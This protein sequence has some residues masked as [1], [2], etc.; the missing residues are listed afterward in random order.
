MD[1]ELKEL[2]ELQAENANVV[3]E[4]SS[5]DASVPHT[6]NISSYGADYDVD[7]L[8]KRMKNGHIF[9]PPFQ[10]DYVW[11]LRDASRLI[12]SLLLGLPV[13]GIFLAK[14]SESNKL[15]VIDGQQR[16]KT[17][18][19]FYEGIFNQKPDDKKV[20]LFRLSNVQPQFEGKLYEDLDEKDKL[21]LNDTIIHATIIKQESPEGDDTSVYH[22]FERLNTGGR[23]LT[24]QEI[25]VAI[26]HGDLIDLLRKLNATPSWRAIFGKESNRLKDQELILRFLAM[27]SEGDKYEKP[28]SEFLSKF[29][30]KCRVLSA[31]QVRQFTE[32]FVKTIDTVYKSVGAHAF[33][34]ERAL[35]AAVFD[36]V[37]VGLAR[38][39]R[40]KGDADPAAVANAYGLLLSDAGFRA[41]MS[42][43]TSDSANVGT[44][45]RL[46]TEK[47]AA[48]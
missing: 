2:E 41:A 18:Q 46:A 34:P 36:S 13:P 10:R 11:N 29:N 15:L 28:M 6:Y 12:E 8:V 33:R 9:I 40:D 43:A 21:R 42:I 48:V 35:N 16:L 20:R 32:I 31:E 17:L 14:E 22:V 39:I 1:D 45:L 25:R 27:Y 23:K 4:A 44:R 24:P 7:G 19:Y 3:D 37:M 38:R 26:F 30:N 5:D 47:F